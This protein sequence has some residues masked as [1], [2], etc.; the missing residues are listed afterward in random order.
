MSADFP[1]RKA[2]AGCVATIGS[3]D[4]VHRGHQCL[5][6]Q[7]RGIADER[8]LDAIAV[9]FAR[10][11]RKVLG[12]SDMAPLNNVEERL[13]LLREMGMDD[14]CVL[15]FTHEMARMTA[16][17]FMYRVLKEQLGVAVLVIGYDHRFGCQR[18]DGFDDYVHYGRELGIEVVRG[19][20]CMEGDEAVS[21]TRIRQCVV[22]GRVAEAAQLL[23]YNYRL[24]GEVVDGYKV[25]RKI[26][27]P[28]ANI[29]MG[30]DEKLLPADGVYA[31][32]CQQTTDNG[33]QTTDGWWMG[34]LNIGHRPTVNN[35]TERSIEVHILDFEGNLYGQTLCIE[36]VE[37]LREERSFASLD[38]LMAQL[39]ADRECVRRIIQQS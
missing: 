2:L 39:I 29:S 3:F 35:G 34:M 10:S 14:V 7:V 6:R 22:E 36:F 1:S 30:H 4:G 32:R 20:A 8:G 21:S 23:G 25:G 26:G 11:P 38:E 18:T 33:Q 24:C 37:R 5:L 13:T 31:V 28:T 15:N 12:G 27:F 17:D 9:T 16:R 19:E